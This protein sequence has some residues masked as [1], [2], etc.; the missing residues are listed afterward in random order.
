[1]QLGLLCLIL[2]WV[3]TGSAD[4][5]KPLELPDTS[6][7]ESYK[8]KERGNVAVSCTTG[9]GQMKKEGDKGFDSCMAEAARDAQPSHPRAGAKDQ[10]AATSVEW[11]LGK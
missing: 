1:M 8:P 2:A 10:K 3:I 5:S 4:E 6:K 7:I 9:D 11:K